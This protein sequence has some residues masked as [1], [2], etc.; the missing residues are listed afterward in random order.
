[1]G[2]PV[3]NSAEELNE[4]V[5]WTVENPPEKLGKG[6]T[7]MKLR[8]WIECLVRSRPFFY[9]GGFL[10]L[11]DLVFMCFRSFNASEAKLALLG[12]YTQKIEKH[13]DSIK[14]L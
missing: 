6:V 12:N 1:M 3:L 9:F 10:V 4:E 13:A 8:W 5:T 2:Y 11:M 14:Q 7:G